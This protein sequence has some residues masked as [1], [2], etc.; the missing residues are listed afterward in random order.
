[1]AALAPW[2][3]MPPKIVTELGYEYSEH[4]TKLL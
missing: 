3:V 1:M 2:L 4:M